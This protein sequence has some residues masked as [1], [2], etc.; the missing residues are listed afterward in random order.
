M[1]HSNNFEMDAFMKHI[2]LLD[3]RE[4]PRWKEYTSNSTKTTKSKKTIERKLLYEWS[5][6]MVNKGLSRTVTKKDGYSYHIKALTSTSLKNP[7]TS[8]DMHKSN[9]ALLEACIDSIFYNNDITNDT[10]STMNANVVDSSN[11]SS[12][13][14]KIVNGSNIYFGKAL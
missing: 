5:I 12:I 9:D 3:M 6:L 14:D 8:N 4:E 2:L 13:L 1:H 10:L 11:V 7:N